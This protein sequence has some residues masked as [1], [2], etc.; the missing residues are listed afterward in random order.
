M[1]FRCNS[2]DY[3]DVDCLVA[4]GADNIAAIEKQ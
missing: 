4:F 1:N 3:A 2:E